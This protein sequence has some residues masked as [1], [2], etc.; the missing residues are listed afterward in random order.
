MSTHLHEQILRFARISTLAF[1]GQLAVT[2]FS[3]I[4]WSVLGSVAVGAVETGVREV[5]PVMPL[6]SGSHA[7][8]PPGSGPAPG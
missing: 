1:L 2:G 5:W 8:Q 3:H 6:P 7:V 4:G